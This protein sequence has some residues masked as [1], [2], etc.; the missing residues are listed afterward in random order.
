[1]LALNYGFEPVVHMQFVQQVL[2]MVTRLQDIMLPAGQGS[3]LAIPRNPAGSM[4]VFGGVA[5]FLRRMA[6]MQEQAMSGFVKD[7]EATYREFF[8]SLGSC[9]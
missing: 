3:S 9:S 7:L 1:M 4:M 8:P 6:Y 5:G 2:N